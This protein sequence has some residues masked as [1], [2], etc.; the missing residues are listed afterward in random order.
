MGFP[1]TELERDLEVGR[2]G[3]EGELGDGTPFL[4]LSLLVGGEGVLVLKWVQL[5]DQRPD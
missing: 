2:E 1:I 5:E 3:R 4:A